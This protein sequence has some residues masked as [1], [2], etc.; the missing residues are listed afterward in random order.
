VK[1]SPRAQGLRVKPDTV[2]VIAG[3]VVVA[4]AGINSVVLDEPGIPW[5]LR[6]AVIIA[7]LWVGGSLI[8]RAFQ[9]GDLERKP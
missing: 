7:L 8:D 9:R 3:Q 1:T 6:L 2:S 5:W 4:F